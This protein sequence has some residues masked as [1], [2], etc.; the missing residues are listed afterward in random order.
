MP[1]LRGIFISRMTT[2]YARSRGHAR[3][4][5][6]ELHLHLVADRARPDDEPAASLHRL[7]TVRGDAEE[8][9]AE[10]ALVDQ[11][12]RQIVGRLGDEAAAGE[13]RLVREQL[14][15]LLHDGVEVGGRAPVTRLAHEL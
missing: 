11:D 9:L 5:V 1:S 4:L 15:R 6:L 3:P 2:S 8:H 14:D 7:Q 10:L 12:L 13:A